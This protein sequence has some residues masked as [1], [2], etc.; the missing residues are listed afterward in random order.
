MSASRSFTRLQARL[1]LD[2]REFSSGLRAARS[3]AQGLERTLSSSFNRLLGVLGLAGIGLSF[4]TITRG[5]RNSVSELSAL[6]KAARDT[7]L[8]VEELQGLMRGFA[9]NTRV[10]GEEASAAFE[11]FNRRVGEAINGAGPLNT[12]IERYGI[13]LRTA[14]GEMRTQS[15]LLRQ[16]AQVIRNARTEQERLAIAQAAFGDSGRRMAAA[17]AGGAE[18]LDDMVAQARES[19]DIISDNLIRRAEILDD[20]FDTLNRRARTFFQTLA[21]GLMAG[22][23]ETS[24]DTLEHLFGS[25]DRARQMLGDG[26]FEPLI[27]ETREL[28]ELEGVTENLTEIAMAYAAVEHALQDTKP[29]L[30]LF[31]V[32]LRQMGQLGAEEVL[33]RL[34]AESEALQDSFAA[35]SISGQEFRAEA[36]RINGRITALIEQFRDMNAVNFDGVIGRVN[37]LTTALAQA[38][39]AAAEATAALPGGNPPG[40]VARGVARFQGASRRQLDMARFG[41][42]EERLASRTREQIALERELEQV[43]RRSRDAGVTLTREQAEAQA[44]LNLQLAAAAN[45]NNQRGGGG[46]GGRPDEFARAVESIREQ[47][48]ALEL[49]AAALVAAATAGNDYGDAIE[50][51][52]RRAELLHAAHRAGIAITPELEAGINSLAEAYVT[53]GRSAQEAA[54]RMNQV[55]AQTERGINAITD[56]FMGIRQGGDAARQAVIRLIAELAR[57]QMYRG[58]AGLAASGSGGF[59]SFLGGLLGGGQIASFAGGGFTGPGARTGGLDGR[60]GFPAILHPNETVIDHTKGGGE[61]Q[62]TVRLALSGDIDARIA[63]GAQGVAVEVVREYDRSALPGR[64]Q[65]ISR[66]PRKRG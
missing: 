61:R 38:A 52:R 25:L 1:G 19:G 43:M 10:S 42:E 45:P 35:G 59:F 64:V 34:I 6:G 39:R 24:I 22:G 17:L 49:E 53:A 7:G 2:R 3:E 9:R 14:N 5:L 29:D 4:A 48:Q 55:R 32:G 65:Q 40:A 63:Q 31:L 8:D 51:A 11:R 62:I 57:V 66:D 21:V 12:T 30:D 37:A 28:R 50:Y 26:I 23:A 33:G 44:R 54:E 41:L 46:G 15:D 27:A 13:S 60:G 36:A 20:K 16:V 58:L 18:A 56:L 47:T